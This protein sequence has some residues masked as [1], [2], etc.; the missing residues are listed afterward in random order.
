MGITVEVSNDFFS[1]E[2]IFCGKWKQKSALNLESEDE[3]LVFKF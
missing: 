1:F 2:N 3:N